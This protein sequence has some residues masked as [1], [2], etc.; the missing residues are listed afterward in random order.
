MCLY[1]DFS[2]GLIHICA[3]YVP[4]TFEVLG[5]ASFFCPSSGS[6]IHCKMYGMMKLNICSWLDAVTNGFGMEHGYYTYFFWLDG[7]HRDGWGT[8]VTVI[9]DKLI[10]TW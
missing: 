9:K 3:P 2:F 4:V 8:K 10:P 7:L 6:L 1:R 5:K